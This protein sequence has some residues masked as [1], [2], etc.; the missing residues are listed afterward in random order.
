MSNHRVHSTSPRLRS[1][2][3]HDQLPRKDEASK[4]TGRL[5]SS[6]DSCHRS[7][8]KCSGSNPCSACLGSQS[9]CTYSRSSKLGRPKGSKNKRTSTQE[10]GTERVAAQAD[11]TNANADVLHWPPL[12]L[13]SFNSGLNQGFD[14]V[15]PDDFVDD[16]LIFDSDAGVTESMSPKCRI[17]L[18]ALL[19]QVSVIQHD[20][21]LQCLIE[22][23]RLLT[24]LARRD[25]WSTI[26]DLVL[27]LWPHRRVVQPCQ[28]QT[29]LHLATT[30]IT[31]LHPYL[32]V[33]LIARVFKSSSS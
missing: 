16:P 7:K 20:W 31:Q 28:D 33:R 19:A 4:K 9:T 3:E 23:A 27:M 29:K 1:C 30:S 15:F 18:Q 13:T 8:I 25:H 14:A 21:L 24:H 17:D 11:T 6:C 26:A 5:R 12:D 10:S 22:L 32:R 2:S